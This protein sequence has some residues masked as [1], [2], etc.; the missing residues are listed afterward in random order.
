ML[1]WCLGARRVRQLQRILWNGKLTIFC[2]FLTVI[3]LWGNLSA[4]KFGTP[5]QDFE[6]IRER[7]YYRKCAEPRGVLV[8]AQ[9]TTMAAESASD[10]NYATFDRY[11]G[12]MGN[13]HPGLGD[14]RWPLVTH[15]VGCKPCGKFGDYPAERCLKQMDRA[16]NFGDNQILQITSVHCQRPAVV[17]VGAVFTFNSVIGRAAKL[18]LEA[19]VFDI[20]ADPSILNGTELK[21]IMKDANCNVFM[22]SIGAF[23]LI[24]GEIVAMIGPQSSAIAHMISQIA[25]GLQVPLISYAATDPTL[26]ASQFPYFFRTTQSDSYQMVAMA[27]LIYF[28]GWK[29]VIAVFVDDDYGR[30]GISALDDE[31]EKKMSKISYKFPL[32]TQFDLSDLTDML[33]KTKFLGPRSLCSSY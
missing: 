17:N 12:M 18:A 33:N 5:Q 7:F 16:F 2:L 26:S 3:V 11:E 21:L 23:Q 20:N 25:N 10:N 13:F 28:Y 1:D 15:F 22:G 6:E 31:L 19:A 30:N 9:T 32:P 4:G 8:K 27:D 29:E 14:H 24:E